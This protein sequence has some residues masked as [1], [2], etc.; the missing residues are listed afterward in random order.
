MASGLEGVEMKK[1][2]AVISVCLFL[3]ISA[4]CSVFSRAH[5]NI[6]VKVG[7]V[8]TCLNAQALQT[9]NIKSSYHLVTN[10]WDN[11]GD[12]VVDIFRRQNNH[13]ALYYACALNETGIG[14]ISEIVASIQWLEQQNVDVVCLSLTA[15]TDDALLRKVIQRLIDKGTTVVAACLNYSNKRTFPASY[16]GVISVAN[17][18]NQ[19]ASI[20]ITRKET[21]DLLMSYKWN[22]C[23]S[24]SL[25]AFVAGTI[26]KKMRN[27]SFDEHTFVSTFNR[28]HCINP[29]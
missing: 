29:K 23:S 20:S 24:S 1:S 27:P 6:P 18:W 9:Y 4:L 25:T 17:C 12:M 16:P 21:K 7:I 19:H 5:T 13:C 2:F 8:D 26:S 28:K 11:H 3:L 15:L 14:D 22:D 10:N